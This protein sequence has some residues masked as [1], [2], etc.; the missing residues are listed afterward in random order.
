MSID[1][2]IFASQKHQD[3]LEAFWPRKVSGYITAVL[4]KTPI[5]PNQTTILWGV[6]SV[7]NSYTVYL[8]LRGSWLAIPLIPLI[9]QFCSVLD[10]VDGEIARFKNMN[11]PI[12]GKL[13]DGICHR[14]TEFSLLATFAMAALV[15]TGSWWALPIGML[16]VTGDGMW[17]YV[18]ERRITAMRVQ[19]G[20]KGRMKR[21][22]AG[23]YVRGARWTELSRRQQLDTVTGLFLYK[24]VYAV[25]A[26]SFLPPPYFLA[27]LTA[28]GVYKHV[29]WIRLMRQ[30]LADVVRLEAAAAGALP[31]AVEPAS[32]PLAPAPA[33]GQE[34]RR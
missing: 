5:T 30:T 22:A 11:S 19:A 3:A 20:Y 26:I 2:G 14:A 24:S 15:T 31:P 18:Y 12:S 4:V 17:V 25:I 9:Y 33:L 27:G 28:L 8:A 21:S 10:C 23:V 29:K 1:P 6:I 7:L 32:P 34:G 16:L 13:L